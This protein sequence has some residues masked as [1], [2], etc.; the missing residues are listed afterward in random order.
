MTSLHILHVDHRSRFAD[1]LSRSGQDHRDEI[2]ITTVRRAA[3]GLQQLRT[4]RDEIDCLVSEY[5]LPDRDG[6]EFL[7]MVRE[8]WSEL[9]FILFT[10]EGSESVASEA[11]SA[12]ATD[13][14][15]KTGSLQQYDLL[16]NRIR[17]CVAR[18]R[19]R[20]ERERVY[21]AL[22]TATEG[23]GLLDDDGQYVYLNDAYAELYGYERAQLVGTH[24]RELYPEAE[25][26]RFHD[27]ILPELTRSGSWTG[28]SRGKRITGETFPEALSL[29]QLRTGG[30]V[31]VVRDVSE[32]LQRERQFETLASNL[33]GMVY[34]CENDPAWPMQHVLGNVEDFLGYSTA[35]LESQDISWREI[36][37]PLDRD[38]VWNAVQD[39]LDEQTTYEITY[40]VTDRN[41][42]TKWVIERGRGITSAD[43]T[44]DH[45]EGLITD[46]TA[47]K[48]RERELEW[49]T[50]AMDEAPMGI[51]ISDPSRDG[52]PLVYVNEH[53]CELTGYRED[54]A[55]GRNCRF[56]QG[57]LTS[58]EPVQEMRDAIDETTAVETD[59]LNY[60]A[61]GTP[62]WNHVQITPIFDTNGE[63]E[64]FVGFQHDI[65][66]R[67]EHKRR[68]EVLHRI[69]LHD[70]RNELNILLGQ[71]P[72]L[73]EQS[74]VDTDT[75]AAIRDPATNLLHSSDKARQIESVFDSA[76]FEPLED[77]LSAFIDRALSQIPAAE[78]AAIRIDLQS[79]PTVVAPEQVSVAFRELIERSCVGDC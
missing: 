7:D 67:V 12:G 58:S 55:L 47:R 9:P 28:R 1:Y 15:Q 19:S 64:Y 46:I 26:H 79:D 35:Q 39:A 59:I 36:I 33:Q 10:D 77:E 51:A 53:F 70:I 71:L 41:G 5:D 13:Y 27:E 48:K 4:R 62:F 49:K 75:I 65:T 23:I 57:P 14:V 3:A 24:W 21:Q 43:G 16:I 76:S 72:S 66:S 61:D 32:R 2:T 42:D 11:I 29:T 22:E 40:R 54:D 30:H 34:R 60:R 45:L 6:L 20:R 56:L 17:N 69:L 44:V 74:D 63:L 52:N 78:D 8:E 31:C 18:F 25:R 37:H 68:I 38:D 50:K 73:A